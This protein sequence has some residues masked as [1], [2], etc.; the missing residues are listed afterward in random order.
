MFAL[1]RKMD[2][3]HDSVPLAR[4]ILGIF[5]YLTMESFRLVTQVVVGVDEL[6]L[7]IAVDRA[8]G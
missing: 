1:G 4:L 2:D 8:R 6:R 5:R 3:L 7:I